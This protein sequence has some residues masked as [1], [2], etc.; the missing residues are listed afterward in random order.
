VRCDGNALKDSSNWGEESYEM[1]C[2]HDN[3]AWLRWA[4]RSFLRSICVV[5]LF[6]AAPSGAVEIG[7]WGFGDGT[8]NDT[9]GPYDLNPVGAGP[10]IA[11]GIAYF[12]G[13]EGSPSYL[14]TGGYGGSADWTIGLRLQPTGPV[15][16]GNFQG[17]VSNNNSAGAANSWQIESFGGVYQLRTTNGTYTIGVPSGGWDVIVVRKIGGNDG[18]I[19]FNGVQVVASFGSNPGGLQNFRIGTNRNS[20][21]FYAFALESLQVFDS[22]EGPFSVPEPGTAVLFGLGLFGLAARGGRRAI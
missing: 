2:R 1:P 10:T 17:I 14:E 3:V 9:V 21:N 6:V 20:N 22:V 12:D 13:L 16:Q 11:G 5:L 8:T 4:H 7:R 15:D 18:D 19:W